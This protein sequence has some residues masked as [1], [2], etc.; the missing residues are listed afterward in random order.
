MIKIDGVLQVFDSVTG[1][2]GMDVTLYLDADSMD[3]LLHNNVLR[4]DKLT[5]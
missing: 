5:D 1:D 2:G 4:S 3:K